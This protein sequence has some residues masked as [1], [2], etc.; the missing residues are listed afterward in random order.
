MKYIKYLCLLFLLLL[1]FNKSAFAQSTDN[2]YQMYCPKEPYDLSNPI[3]RGLQSITGINFLTSK[4]AASQIKKTIK[5]FAQGDIKVKVKSFSATD[6]KN[7][8]FKGFE[9]KGKD[10]NFYSVYVS[11]LKAKSACDF[12]YLNLEKNPIEL[13]EP[14]VID[15][16]VKFTE[17]DLNNMLKTITYNKYM[18]NI[19]YNNTNLSLFELKK[20]RVSLKN[21]KFHF[22]I[23]VRIPFVT[24]FVFNVKSDLQISNNKIQLKNF[25]FGSNRKTIDLSAAKYIMNVLNPLWFAQ[26]LLQEHNCKFLLKNVRIDNEKIIISGAV[27]LG[28]S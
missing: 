19:K 26:L 20:P 1:G 28:K 12:I 9:I 8:R 18:L 13:K 17:D 7:G 24:S 23:D 5:S 10:L 2:M 22:A 15:F 21:N 6:A 16:D 4:V 11:E 25:S 3:S 14:M 27:F